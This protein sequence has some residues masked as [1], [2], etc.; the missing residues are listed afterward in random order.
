[1]FSI[2]G[3]TGSATYC[4]AK[5]GQGTYPQPYPTRAR[6]SLQGRVL[7]LQ[8]TTRA[9]LRRDGGFRA[10]DRVRRMDFAFTALTPHYEDCPIQRI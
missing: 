10:G 7:T 5:E 3:N 6:C 2:V 9:S 4:I 1:M 8:G